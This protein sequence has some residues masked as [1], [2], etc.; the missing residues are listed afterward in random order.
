M[1]ALG[2]VR[3]CRSRLLSPDAPGRSQPARLGRA[4]TVLTAVVM[5]WAFALAVTA[6]PAGVALAAAVTDPPPVGDAT[7]RATTATTQPPPTVPAPLGPTTT[8]ELARTAAPAVL[9]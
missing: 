6:I 9:C 4:H 2:I 1:L 5:L 7:S 3:S 8:P